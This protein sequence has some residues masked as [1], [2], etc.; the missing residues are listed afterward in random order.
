MFDFSALQSAREQAS[1]RDSQRQ[2][3]ADDLYTQALT[4]LK[5]FQER[6][7]A[8]K[9]LLTRAAALLQESLTL[10]PRQAS[11]CLAMGYIFFVLGD[12]G[13]AHRYLNAGHSLDPALVG[14]QQLRQCLLSA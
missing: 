2:S 11:A 5:Q 3:R 7:G 4:L 9:S 10:N 12:S 1:D 8:Q 14:I 6:H 13:R